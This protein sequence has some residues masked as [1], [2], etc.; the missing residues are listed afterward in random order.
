MDPEDAI[1]FTRG[2]HQERNEAESPMKTNRCSKVEGREFEMQEK[3]VTSGLTGYLT[4]LVATEEVS[5]NVSRDRT[6]NTDS[7]IVHQ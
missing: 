4:L 5:A 1:Q 3:E 7:Y 6:A 2:H